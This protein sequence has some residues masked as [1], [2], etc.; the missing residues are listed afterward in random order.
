MEVIWSRRALRDVR[1]IE[2]H[3]AADNPLAARRLA[4]RLIN[5]GDSLSD[6]PLRG[7]RLRQDVRELTFV[8]PYLLRYRL[9]GDA[10]RILE[11]RHGARRP[12]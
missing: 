5:A 2:A 8:H 3:I 4:L 1:G 6:Q 9:I 12:D 11:I 7:R 10:V